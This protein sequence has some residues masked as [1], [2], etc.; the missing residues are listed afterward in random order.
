MKSRLF[1]IGF[2][3]FIELLLK[4]QLNRKYITTWNN[5]RNNY[6]KVTIFSHFDPKIAEKQYY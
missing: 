1:N 3:F 4:L 6:I 5:N 2:F